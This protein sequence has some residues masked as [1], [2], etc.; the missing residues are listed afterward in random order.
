MENVGLW[1]AI[2]TGSAIVAFWIYLIVS[3][4]A[5]AG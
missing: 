5:T 1:L 4:L 3:A 2:G